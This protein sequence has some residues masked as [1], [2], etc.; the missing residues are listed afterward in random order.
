MSRSPAHLRL[1]VQGPPE[2]PVL[3]G[4]RILS[5][6][7]RGLERAGAE[8]EVDDVAFVRLKPVQLDRRDRPD[9]QPIDVDG[10]D[11]ASGGTAG[12]T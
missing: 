6:Q 2:N 5:L 8:Q 11:E 9:I 3:G 10:V 7:L 1:R 12:L 4:L